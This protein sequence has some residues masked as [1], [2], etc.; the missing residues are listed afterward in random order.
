MSDLYFKS[1]RGSSKKALSSQAIVSGIAD[2]G[3]L[4]IPEFFPKIDKPLSYL[5]EMNYNELAFYIMEK[6][7][8]DFEDSVLQ[9]CIKKA[10]DSKFGDPSIAPLI[11]KRGA[12]F[13][14]LYHGPTLAF[15]DMALSILPHLLK[16]ACIRLDIDKEIVILTATSGDTGKAALEGFSDVEGTKIIVFYP[17]DGVSQIQ[18]RQMITQEGS[19]TYVIAIEGN[20]DDAQK[21]VKEIFN[22]KSFNKILRN[23]NYIFSSA[24]SINIGRLIPQIVYYVYSYLNLNKLGKIG[25]NERVNIVVPTGNFGNILAAYYAKKMGIPINRLICASNENNVL[26]DFI[27]TGVYD[28]RRKLKTTSSPSMDILVSS[29]LERLL[30]D[31]CGC[32]PAIVSNL[33]EKLNK[34]GEYRITS[35]MKHKLKVFYGGFATDNE[36]SKTIRDVYKSLNYLIDPHTAV[37]YNVYQKYV[38]DTRDATETIIASTASPFKFPNSVMKAI[39]EKFADYDDFTLLEKIAKISGCSIPKSLKGID[40][41]KIL[42]NTVCKK[43][44]MKSIV[45]RILKI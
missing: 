7:F 26:Y 45:S 24:N 20:F 11:E 23:N 18:E 42:H 21:G 32:N 9:K 43:E 29:N 16:A 19:N 15:K 4:Y 37:A 25:R 44:D 17:Q 34:R 38:R 35:D 1:T 10:Y 12:Y 30:Y 5:K 2:D 3:G 40:K 39:D 31:L 28:K 22:D 33:I 36:V 27:K 13:L 14:E 41:R 6:F 8:T